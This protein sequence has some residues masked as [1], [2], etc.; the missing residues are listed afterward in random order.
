MKQTTL[1]TTDADYQT[2]GVERMLNWF[3]HILT[4]IVKLIAFLADPMICF[5]CWI[6]TKL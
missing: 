5:C 1:Y 6:Q 3:W 4:E 2:L